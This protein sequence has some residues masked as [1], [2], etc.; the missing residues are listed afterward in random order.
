MSRLL[1]ICINKNSVV[2]IYFGYFYFR[3]KVIHKKSCLFI[4][5]GTSHSRS[6]AINESLL[7]TQ[8]IFEQ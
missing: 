8:A 3:D 2:L 7:S 5:H 4:L 1:I 6:T